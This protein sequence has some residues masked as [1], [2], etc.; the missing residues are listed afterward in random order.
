M[1]KRITIRNRVTDM[2]H[3]F[4]PIIAAP[5]LLWGDLALAK[6]ALRQGSASFTP[7]LNH[8]RGSGSAT[9]V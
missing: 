3:L 4:H 2:L 5:T 8:Q 1:N 9:D 6:K 7:S